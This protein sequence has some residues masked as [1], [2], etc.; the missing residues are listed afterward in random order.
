MLRLKTLS[1][2]ITKDEDRTAKKTHST[3]LNKNKDQYSWALKLDPTWGA[4]KES[5]LNLIFF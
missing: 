4:S 5:A 2:L 3:L 1:A